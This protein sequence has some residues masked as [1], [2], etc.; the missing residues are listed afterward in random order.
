M[1]AM[2][3]PTAATPTKLADRRTFCTLATVA[4]FSTRS[5]AKIQEATRIS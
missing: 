2:V 1:M 4:K 3:M 5:A